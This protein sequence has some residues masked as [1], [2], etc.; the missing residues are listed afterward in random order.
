MDTDKSTFDWL[1]E[2]IA[3]IKSQRFHI[4]ESLTSAESVYKTEGVVVPPVGDYLEF[5]KYFGY[6]RMFTDHRDS[7][8]VSVYSLKDS[9]RHVCKN[10]SVFV[11][12]GYRSYQSVYF[13]EALILNGMQSPVYT[14]NTNQGKVIAP[15][16]SE[17]LLDAYQWA[18][19]KYSAKR[20]ASILVGP[21][22]FSTSEQNIAN[23]T[24]KFHF[25]LVGFHED[26]DA[27]IRVKNGSTLTLPYFSIGAKDKSDVVLIGAVWLNTSKI[28][29]NQTAIVKHGCYKDQI[30]QDELMLFRCDK[31]IPEKREA[32][33]E[34]K[35]IAN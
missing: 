9:R 34:F 31:P 2:E 15:N 17:W 13:D 1:Q 4:F 3:S 18:K 30:K 25:E 19:S 16:F 33:W 12:F 10:G 35:N 26:G 28:E 24:E 5:L 21:Q 29:P 27:L 14:V 20:W 32:Y 11:G 7:P 22:P 8:E 23:A 6:A